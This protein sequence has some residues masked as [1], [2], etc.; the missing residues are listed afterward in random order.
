ME[1]PLELQ[2]IV[3]NFILNAIKESQR[4][5]RRFV[6]MTYYTEFELKYFVFMII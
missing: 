6:R 4:K 2:F 1:Q 5:H 3:D